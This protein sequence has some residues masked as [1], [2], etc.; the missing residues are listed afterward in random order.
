MNKKEEKLQKHLEEFQSM[1]RA[2]KYLIKVRQKIVK[3]TENI[4]REEL[5][6]EAEYRDWQRLESLSMQALF[7]RVLGNKTERIERERQ[8]YLEAVLT[9]KQSHKS[10]ELLQFDEKI[11]TDKVQSLPQQ[12]QFI[13][14][15]ILERENSLEDHQRKPEWLAFFKAFDDAQKLGIEIREAKAVGKKCQELT[16]YII[17]LLQYAAELRE[18]GIKS[19][20]PDYYQE[21]T[22]VDQAMDQFYLLYLEL[23]KFEDEVQDIELDTKISVVAAASKFEQSVEVYHNHLINDWIVRSRISSVITMMKSLL[24]EVMDLC[25]AVDQKEQSTKDLLLALENKQRLLIL[26]ELK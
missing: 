12:Q 24:K 13:Q 22:T 9:L 6:V 15:L 18:W 1:L 26:Q 20:L 3:E 4:Q 11:L 7:S 5:L 23:Q 8:E 25:K 16:Q 19:S 17:E 14:D 2:Q 10:L 21:K